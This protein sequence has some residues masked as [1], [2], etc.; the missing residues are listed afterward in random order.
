MVSFRVGIVM[1]VLSI[2]CTKAFASESY[3]HAVVESCKGCQLNR[4]P[5]VK[6]FIFED[7]PKYNNVEFKHI[8]GA[9]PELVLY[10]DQEQEVERLKL[11]KLIRDELN[12]LLV[13]KGFKKTHDKEDL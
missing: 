1:L 10:N 13:S 12:D 8:Q 5:D 11:A 3:S 4:L 2:F 9:P 6:S 7:V